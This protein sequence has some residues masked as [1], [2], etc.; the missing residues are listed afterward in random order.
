MEADHF[1]SPVQPP[2]DLSFG[3]LLSCSYRRRRHLA[4]GAEILYIYLRIFLK[5]RMGILEGNM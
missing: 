5:K 4:A 3:P 1:G 2:N